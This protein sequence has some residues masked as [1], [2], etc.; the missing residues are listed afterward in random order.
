MKE[1][2]KT[3]KVRKNKGGGIFSAAFNRDK[4]GHET[5]TIDD[6]SRY[7]DT[8]IWRA[9]TRKSYGSGGAFTKLQNGEWLDTDFVTIV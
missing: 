1:Q 4:N 2:T 9:G 5:V 7:G 3:V 6:G 8:Y